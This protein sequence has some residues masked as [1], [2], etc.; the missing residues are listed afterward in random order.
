VVVERSPKDAQAGDHTVGDLD[1]LAMTRQ[2]GN[3]P[4]RNIY[5]EGRPGSRMT[6]SHYHQRQAGEGPG[7]RSRAE[8]RIAQVLDQEGIAYRYEHPL[9]VVDQ[10]KTRIWYPDF[11]LPEYGMILEYFGVHGDA[12]YDRRTEHKLKVYEST[13]VEGVFLNEDSLRR[14]G[15]TGITRQIESVLQQRLRRFYGRPAQL[16]EKEI[17]ADRR[18]GPQLP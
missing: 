17:V 18:A 3:A 13:G 12:A 5:K 2:S 15:S 14:H 9:A 4:G 16:R 1:Q 10:G 6:E 8:V 7:Y 11:Y